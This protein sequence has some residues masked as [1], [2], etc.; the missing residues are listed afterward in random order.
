MTR[1]HV[2]H[3]MNQRGTVASWIRA[4]VWDVVKVLLI[5]LVLK[6]LVVD[7]VRIPSASMEPLLHGDPSRFRGDYVAVNKLAYGLRVPFTTQRIIS[8]GDVRRW[9]VVVFRNPDPEADEPMLIKR[10]VGLPG[11]Q[12]LI[13]KGAV[14][15]NGEPLTP[16]PDLADTLYYMRFPAP[17]PEAV[18]DM[19]LS[20]AQRQTIPYVFNPEHVDF[21]ILVEDIK[22]LYAQIGERDLTD[23][24]EADREALI[25][26]VRPTSLNF[27]ADWLALQYRVK[28]DFS[29]GVHAQPQFMQI[30]PGHYYL[31]GDNSRDS[32]DSRAF[33]W[34]PRDALYGR[35]FAI[36]L[37]PARIRDLSGFTQTWWG[38]LLL[39]GIP[40]L[41]VLYEI[42]RAFIFGTTR[43]TGR[44]NAADLRP[45]DRVL[46][47][48]AA[49]GL[50]APFARTRRWHFHRPPS[51]D[52][53]AYTQ[54]GLAHVGR[55][56]DSDPPTSSMQHPEFVTIR[57]DSS[58][59]RVPPGQ[60]DGRVLALVWPWGRRRRFH[61][62]GSA[63]GVP[64]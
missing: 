44:E 59:H 51:G 63:S 46:V 41:I 5:V 13:R 33:G 58:F 60:I 24:S 39:V 42:L 23:L 22:A 31:L 61:R 2:S 62:Q 28:S 21:H 3:H 9:D 64:E 37:P 14:R 54:D 4:R 6:W 7:L 40:L 25:A 50:R 57:R 53:V 43:L 55:I 35:A 38:P 45:G 11:E 20:L 16:P 15:V 48:R 56:V 1:D 32:V 36:V 34:V 18:R 19:L 8:W 10:V 12:V 27:I 17:S 52:L 29:Y 30:P 26:G 47:H 49:Y